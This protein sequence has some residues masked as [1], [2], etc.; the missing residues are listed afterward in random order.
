M[1]LMQPRPGQQLAPFA[2]PAAPAQ[3]QW[4]PVHASP[5]PAHE[6]PHAPQLATS[7]AVSA[8]TPEQ[9]ACVE[10]LHA[11]PWQRASLRSRTTEP[12]NLVL[13]GW[14]TPMTSVLVAPLAVA[15]T[16]SGGAASPSG[17]SSVKSK[18]AANL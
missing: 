13:I 11:W 18:V 17:G 1:R 5:R 14:M 7:P 12:G 10:P 15:V 6:A 3:R 2:Q 8:H 9:H 16:I 4:V